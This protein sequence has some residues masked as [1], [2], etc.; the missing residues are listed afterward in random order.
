MKIHVQFNELKRRKKLHELGKFFE[1]N[2][3]FVIEIDLETNSDQK[4]L[5]FI[6]EMIHFLVRIVSYYFNKK[7][8]IISEERLI[9]TIIK[10]IFTDQSNGKSIKK[11]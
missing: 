3:E 7:I 8:S 1:Q 11:N 5:T 9:K 4:I 2:Q 10:L 6:E